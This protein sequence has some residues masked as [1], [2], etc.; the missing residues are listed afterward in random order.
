MSALVFF[1]SSAQIT[2]TNPVKLELPD[3]LVVLKRTDLEKKTG[4]IAS[5]KYITIKKAGGVPMVIQ[6]DDLNGDGRWDEAA[7]LYSFKPNE[8]LVLKPVITDAP[9]TVKAVVRAHVRQMRKNADNTFGPAVDKDTMPVNAQPTDFSKQ[10]LPPYLTEGPAWENDKVG[11]RLYF[12]VRNGKD[13]WGK[14]TTRMVLD[15]VG[16]DT[17]K[18]YHHQADWGMDILKVGA[19][20]GAGSLALEVKLPNGKDTL[21]RLGGQHIEQVTY[22]KVA[23]GSVRAICRLHYKNWT[24]AEGMAP[25]SVTEEI[26]IW[27]GQYFYESRVTVAGAPANAKLVTGIVNLH[28]KQ[29]HELNAKGSKAIYT[30]DVQSEN[31]DKLGMAVVMPA[32]QVA[33]TATTPNANTDVQNTYVIKANITNAKP[34]VYRFYAGWEKSDTRF[35]TAEGFKQFLLSEIN[36]MG[37]SI[38]K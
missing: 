8:K 15:E 36:R 31:K 33:A 27:G 28:S 18:N 6:F 19:S 26:H 22:E 32:V 7:F 37:A 29:V 1:R 20:L 16:A 21:V 12:D 2:L 11:F 38:W 35:T 17:A 4:P 14:T 13:I 23:D 34:V 30:Y 24:I 3:E 25:V 10:A 9:A 5:G